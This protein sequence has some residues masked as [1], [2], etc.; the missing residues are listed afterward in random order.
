MSVV[1]NMEAFKYLRLRSL[2]AS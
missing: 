2:L 1:D